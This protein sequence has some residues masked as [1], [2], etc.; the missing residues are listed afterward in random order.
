LLAVSGLD[1]YYGD[2]H[3]LWDVTLEVAPRSITT[4][5]GSNGAGKTT[6]LKT[7]S[8]LLRPRVGTIRLDGEPIEGREPHRIAALG[9][10]HVPEGRR[11]FP[12]MTVA[13]NLA[14]GAYHPAVRARERQN[15]EWVLAL[16]PV[17]RQ[18]LD[19]LAG[20]MS[21]GEQQ[22][23]AIG[24]ALMMEPKLVLMD[25]PS[26]GLQPTLVTLLFETIRK[27]TERGLT[28]LLV[29]QNVQESLEIADRFYILETGRVVRT[30]ESREM[31]TDAHLRE[32]Y[33]GL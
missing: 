4:L 23:L 6:L 22:M 7:I 31:L 8:G 15:L 27:I 21:G 24:R 14:L 9:V 13:E 10:A 29:E 25:E 1:V 33:L 11:I 19:Q 28:V 16:F 12:M 3:I 32:A 26:Q 20:T 18:R 17:L 2:L 5:I 30:G